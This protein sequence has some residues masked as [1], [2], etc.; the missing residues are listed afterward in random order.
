MGAAGI[1]L[2]VVPAIGVAAEYAIEPPPQRNNDKCA[3]RPGRHTRPSPL[4]NGAEPSVRDGDRP[5]NAEPVP[6]KR[7]IKPR[8]FRTSSN[9]Y[10][11][12]SGSSTHTAGSIR[13][14]ARGVADE[15]PDA[16]ADDAP[17]MRTESA[18]HRCAML[19]MHTTSASTE[20]RAR[21]STATVTGDAAV[22]ATPMRGGPAGGSLPP[23]LPYVEPFGV[24]S[25]LG[26]S[27]HSFH[28]WRTF[29]TRPRHV[30]RRGFTTTA[31]RRADYGNVRAGATAGGPVGAGVVPRPVGRLLTSG[32]PA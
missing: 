4:G 28:C 8:Q 21:G 19:A 11:T 9:Q 16:S 3:D 6:N 1:C 2:F 18:P 15:M 32:G 26:S 29:A 24:F 27:L 23:P 17:S 12:C 20:E 31:L 14:D 7:A 30:R 25:C 10:R 22:T 5:I 13:E